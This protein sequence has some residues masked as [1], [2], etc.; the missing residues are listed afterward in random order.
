M[1]CKNQKYGVISVSLDYNLSQPAL[2]T[3]MQYLK[4]N[5]LLDITVVVTYVS[6]W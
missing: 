5:K 1:Q 3:T 2:T 6:F 4:L